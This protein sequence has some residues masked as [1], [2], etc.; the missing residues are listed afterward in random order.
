MMLEHGGR[1][2]AYDPSGAEGMKQGELAVLCPACPRP[3]VNLPDG[4]EN[5]APEQRQV[6]LFKKNSRWS[7]Y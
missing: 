1:V 3:G 7:E 6:L 2:E 5:R 4:W